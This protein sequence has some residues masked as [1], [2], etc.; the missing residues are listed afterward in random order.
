MF[1]QLFS[2][3]LGFPLHDLPFLGGL[4][5]HFIYC[6]L[7]CYAVPSFFFH[8]FLVTKVVL[9]GFIIFLNLRHWLSNI[10]FLG[11]TRMPL[12]FFF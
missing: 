10:F 3:R 1:H 7:F 6:F 2:A 8:I 5:Y 12:F 9:V 4:F 11:F